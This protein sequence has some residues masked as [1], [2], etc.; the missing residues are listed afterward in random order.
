MEID[1]NKKLQYFAKPD[2]K[3]LAWILLLLS[4]S[5]MHKDLVLMLVQLVH[6]RYVYKY[7]IYNILSLITLGWSP[8]GSRP[9]L[10]ELK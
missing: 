3:L 2:F 7:N 6:I 10:M 5:F 4:S 8:V 1:N 9:F